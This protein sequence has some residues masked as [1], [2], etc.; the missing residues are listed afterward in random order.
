MLLTVTAASSSAV[1]NPSDLGYLLHKHPDRVQRF[2][3]PVGDA[4]VFYPVVSGNECGVALILEVDPIDLVRSRF[5]S[6]RDAF[7]L[8]QY[9]NDRP[10]AGSSLLAVAIS[11]VFG[12]ALA[13]TCVARPDLVDEAFDLTVHVPAMPVRGP[14]EA[15]GAGDL[16]ERL[17]GPL[18]WTVDVASIALDP[19]IPEWGDS[20]YVTLTLR[21]TLTVRDALRHL[22]VLLPVLDDVKHYWVGEDEA[23]KLVRLAGDWLSGHPDAELISSRYLAHRRELVASVVDRLIGDTVD[24]PVAT[25]NPPLARERRDSVVDALLE[26]GANTVV[27]IGCGEGRLIELLLS[28]REFTR[29]VGTDTSA[30]EL[31]RAERRLGIT[32]MSDER[33]NRVSLLHSSATYRDSRLTGFDAAV[34]MEVI[35][36]VD[37]ARL[38]SL[39]RS[40]FGD[41]SPAAVV[42]TTPNSEFNVRYTGLTPG[43]FR[44]PDHRFEFDRTQFQAWADDVATSHGYSVTIDFIGE[45]DPAL[46]GP[47]QRA[48]FRKVVTSP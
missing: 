43:Q 12:S 46:G 15:S 2:G 35:E 44:H 48:I 41:A 25:P 1:P 24:A 11:R 42:V 16:A 14:S 32:D 29:V 18:G 45:H 26:L 19:E 20:A 13:G 30:R 38:P 10:Y 36:H 22:Y 7:A 27:D 39:V 9:V 8:G 34:L 40:V 3:L 23:D 17:F 31:A 6:G 5:R 28:R 37:L 33:R 47:T 4:S 21:G